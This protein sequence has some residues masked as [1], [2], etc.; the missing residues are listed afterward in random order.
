MS[1]A[2]S[3]YPYYTST[4]WKRLIQTFPSSYT[5]WMDGTEYRADC[6]VA[7]GNDLP[8]T[9]NATALIQDAI[10]NISSGTVLLRDA[11]YALEGTRLW[12]KSNVNVIGESIGGTILNLANGM[13]I[14]TP[15]AIDTENVTISNMTL[16]SGATS[17]TFS[18]GGNA[19]TR[20]RH[21]SL[22]HLKV[23]CNEPYPGTAG[24]NIFWA[25]PTGANVE[26]GVL[27]EYN[28]MFDVKLFLNIN[29]IADC[30]SISCQRYFNMTN[31]YMEAR[32]AVF[33]T[34]DSLF[35]N[36]IIHFKNGWGNTGIYLTASNY[37]VAV[38]GNVLLEDTE[39]GSPAILLVGGD[40]GATYQKAINV[41]GNTTYGFTGG[42]MAQGNCIGC[43]IT[44]NSVWESDGV[45]IQLVKSVWTANPESNTI[46]GNTIIDANMHNYPDLA[47]IYLDNADKTTVCSNTVKKINSPLLDYGIMV[48]QSDNTLINGLISDNVD[49]NGV[50]VDGSNYTHIGNVFV[51]TDPGS[52]GI[53][54]YNGSDYTQIRNCTLTGLTYPIEIIGAHSSG[55]LEV[56]APSSLDLSGAAS[57]ILVFQATCPC[58]L[59]GYRIFYTEASSGDAGV[60]VRIGRYQD[61]VA[62]DD[63][64]F[65][66]VVSEVSKN[67]G[68]SKFYDTE[69]LSLPHCVIST[70]DS[71]T[72][73]TAGGK[74]GAGE[75]C[76]TLKIA[77]I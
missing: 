20:R 67:L 25:G 19:G 35:N 70:G 5:V 74:A 45:G 6:N 16:N 33:L 22:Q 59:L 55:D 21:I 60:N 17:A 50:R 42:V 41:I 38:S 48:Y 63:D 37:N 14:A 43:S 51:Q 71:V 46:T 64:Y 7:G 10:D 2:E 47:G 44:G 75:V 1:K 15:L 8:N 49:V 76:L 24:L 27:D 53:Y 31:C 40:A 28:S 54:E 32:T 11:S 65:D 58:Q 34:R 23:Y 57:D 9:D 26:T 56:I 61:G 77:Y 29:N 39:S 13:E 66:V 62:L 73:G 52:W 68:Y 4:A 72:V 69:A 12:L 3:G 36:N 18:F 30:N